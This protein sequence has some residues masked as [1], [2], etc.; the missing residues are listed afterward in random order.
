MRA[1][2]MSIEQHG[3]ESVGE[4][5]IPEKTR[6]PV[7]S[8]L[9]S[10]PRG[11][12]VAERLAC[13]PPT[14]ANRSTLAQSPLA[15]SPLRAPVRS[16]GLQSSGASPERD[17]IFMTHYTKDK[18]MICDTPPYQM[19]SVRSDIWRLC[20][21][22]M[23]NSHWLCTAKYSMGV[24]EN[25][26]VAYLMTPMSWR[27]EPGAKRKISSKSV[28]LS[29]E[30]PSINFATFVSSPHPQE[31]VILRRTTLQCSDGETARQA[32]RSDEALNVRGTVARIAL[33]LLDRLVFLPYSHL[34]V[35]TMRKR[36]TPRKQKRKQVAEHNDNLKLTQKKHG[37]GTQYSGQEPP[38]CLPAKRRLRHRAGVDIDLASLNHDVKE[39]RVRFQDIL[40]RTCNRNNIASIC[41]VLLVDE[42]VTKDV[43]R[44]DNNVPE[45]MVVIN[46]SME[47]HQNEI[48][49]KWEI[50]KK[51]LRPTV[52]SG[53]IPTCEHPVARLV[54]EP[55]SPWWEASSLTT[56]PSWPLEIHG[57][58][59]LKADYPD[60]EQ[61]TTALRAE[62][63]W[64]LSNN[65]M[66]RAPE[67]RGDDA[68]DAH[69]SVVFIDP[70]TLG[71]ERRRKLDFIY[72]FPTYPVSKC[73]PEEGMGANFVSGRTR[74]AYKGRK[75][76]KETCIAAESDGKPWRAIG[77]VSTSLNVPI[78]NL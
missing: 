37:F 75:S 52:L 51:T 5:E 47:R 6:R 57:L 29:H 34:T 64:K 44:G 32:S 66:L 62:V 26:R 28:D 38:T 39:V 35:E 50:P 53:T 18:S 74:Y 4:R 58:L 46:V 67:H 7:V 36:C 3:N 2:E 78:V 13:S 48:A 41:T 45:P 61:T 31:N 27:S 69:D 49:G 20:F 1:I 22:S 42:I 72:L 65:K 56:Q 70:A 77:A 14:K 8:Q 43:Y 21:D 23:L 63:C 40:Y 60:K 73:K 54:I 12:A 15:S 24:D 25:F 11:A 16:T 71:L 19:L 10:N 59:Y 55:G 9:K 33:S 30:K 17:F 68:L 76:C